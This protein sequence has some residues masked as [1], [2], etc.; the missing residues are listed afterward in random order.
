MQIVVLFVAGE[1]DL[2]ARPEDVEKIHGT[3]ARLRAAARAARTFR[4]SHVTRNNRAIEGARI[5]D[6]R[7]SRLVSRI[8]RRRLDSKKFQT[9]SKIAERCFRENIVAFDGRMPAVHWMEQFRAAQIG[10]RQGIRIAH[11]HVH[12]VRKVAAQFAH[13]RAQFFIH[14]RGKTNQIGPVNWPEGCEIFVSS[15]KMRIA[16]R[17]LRSQALCDFAPFEIRLEIDETVA[18]RPRPGDAACAHTQSA[19]ASVARNFLG[20]CW[21]CRCKRLSGCSSSLGGLRHAQSRLLCPIAIRI[22][23]GNR[24]AASN[25]PICPEKLRV[26]RILRK[27]SAARPRDRP[28]RRCLRILSQ[29]TE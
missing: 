17:V 21:L 9:W 27:N 19:A 23:S 1:F 14:H 29:Q 11:L 26:R 20:K 2:I 4:L 28:A 25:W 6:C 13:H 8:R 5:I 15:F 16:G 7:R 18:P 10:C 24:S 22:K 12:I 3:L